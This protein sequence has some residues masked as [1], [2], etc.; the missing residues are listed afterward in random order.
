[1]SR[2]PG[3]G[4]YTLTATAVENLLAAHLTGDRQAQTRE[5]ATID[6]QRTS[7][8]GGLAGSVVS[9]LLDAFATWLP[10]T[11]VDARRLRQGQHA[12]VV[13]DCR[14]GEL[15][16]FEVKAQTTKTLEDLVQADW[17]RNDTD[18]LAS[19]VLGTPSI[20]TQLS[21]SAFTRLSGGSAL[22]QA[23]NPSPYLIASDLCLLTS[24]D[25]RRSVGVSN[26]AELSSYADLK[27]LVHLASDGLRAIQLSRIPVVQLALSGVL[28]DIRVDCLS[29]STAVRLQGRAS[30]QWDFA[31]YIYDSPLPHGRHKL[32]SRALPQPD[33]FV[34]IAGRL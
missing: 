12:D 19:I 1:M 15:L 32:H 14:G 2:N 33:L 5:I 21:S 6:L 22:P 9:A 20:A 4:L 31:Y 11:V 25:K 28:P 23:N 30:T 24:L 13:A 8:R 26:L 10:H 34:P 16:S 29:K 3:S 17:I 18:G 27:Y 7:G